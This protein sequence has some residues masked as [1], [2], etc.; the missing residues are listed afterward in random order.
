VD[1]A[2]GNVTAVNAGGQ[3][4]AL[5]KGASVDQ[6]ETIN[7]NNGRA[8]LRFT[9][10][11]Y[12]S[13]QPES[14]FRIDQYRFE[15]KADGSEKG[16]FS[17]LKGGLRTITGLV[18][19]S[20]R[21]NYQVTTTVATIGIRGTEYTIQYGQSVA[22]TVGEG[23]IEVCN[24]A[25]CLS[26]T[27]GE[28]YYVQNQEIKP[29]LSNKKTDLPPP[30]PQ[31]PPPTF[32]EGEHVSETG[33]N[34]TL[35]PK[36]CEA[37]PLPSVLT[38]TFNGGITFAHSTPTSGAGNQ[39]GTSISYM[40]SATLDSSGRL[41]LMDDCCGAGTGGGTVGAGD[42]SV[43][44]F[45]NDGIITWGRL[46]DGT[47]SGTGGTGDVHAG[48]V[49]TSPDSFHYIIGAPVISRP[50]GTANFSFLGGTVPTFG[51]VGTGSASGSAMLGT[52]TLTGASMTADFGQN[53]ISFT[54]GLKDPS[55]LPI[56][57]AS[58]GGSI[59]A[60]LFAGAGTSISTSGSGACS[61]ACRV[62]I[63]GFFAGA[64]AERA[65]FSY[66]VDGVTFNC[67]TP[68]CNAIGV[69]GLKR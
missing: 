57:F 58:G 8:Q 32:A 68:P 59:S 56:D 35:D 26:V 4:R 51:P 19:R 5:A 31:N 60:A 2:I 42:T 63:N 41:V 39:A 52:G 25:G 44:E 48:G 67:G 24:G 1:F 13:L 43:K 33:E 37:P 40:G 15:G 47:L 29:V 28:S 62:S 36:A 34:C 64:N 14:Q 7:T 30:S 54:L 65:G 53:T 6:G 10:G 23:Q 66:A 20:N 16:L 49:Y 17:L 50:I 12:V 3:S 9:D 45:F 27:D 61:G 69:V 22:G 46:T 55:G 11:A 18:G 21:K 38:G